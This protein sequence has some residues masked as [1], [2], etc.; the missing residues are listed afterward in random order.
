[1]ERGLAFRVG[2]KI[3]LPLWKLHVLVANMPCGVHDAERVS[4]HLSSRKNLLV[5]WT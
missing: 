5:K 3:N 2:I 1:M 4:L